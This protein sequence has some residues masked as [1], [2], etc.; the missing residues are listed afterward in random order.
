MAHSLYIIIVG[1]GRL[2]SL[3]ATR[4]SGQGH[5]VV[6]IDNSTDRL[7]RLSSSEFSGFR[8]LGDAVEIE[9]LREA[10]MQQAD[11]VL[12]TT[13][14]DNIN[15]MVAQIARRVF[16]VKK[17]IARV[18]DP[19][20]EMLYRNFDIETI[21]PTLLSADVFMQVMETPNGERKV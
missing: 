2:G 16:H 8:I 5:Q 6:V 19:M 21:S 11:C 18:Y 13:N 9:T 14:S 15:L 20:C 7:N 10:K 17:V 4:L 3:L 1:C 12:A